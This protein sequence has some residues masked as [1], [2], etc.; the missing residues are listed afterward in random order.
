MKYLNLFL[1]LFA[2]VVLFSCKG[3]E[4]L[5]DCD[6]ESDFDTLIYTLDSV[7]AMD[8]AVYNSNGIKFPLDDFDTLIRSS[9]YQYFSDI[10]SIY[11]TSN[12]LGEYFEHYK[13]LED[14]LVMRT[15]F[16]YT[17]EDNIYSF[18]PLDYSSTVI[19]DSNEDDHLRALNYGED[20]AEIIENLTRTY[21]LDGDQLTIQ[22]FELRLSQGNTTIYYPTQIYDEGIL[23]D[24]EFNEIL[25]VIKYSLVY[26]L[27]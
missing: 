11:L 20:D 9:F 18:I 21:R 8:Y 26:S 6:T 19:I 12:Y 17:K 1:V 3:D 4:N 25:Y 23:T 5:C 7:I 24:L 27:K 16:S 10:D 2:M 15:R 22:L 14:T 13:F